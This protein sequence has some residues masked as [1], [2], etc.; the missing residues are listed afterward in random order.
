MRGVTIVQSIQPDSAVAPR[1]WL[2]SKEFD[3]AF[4]GGPALVGL[5]SAFAVVSNPDLWG[6]ILLADLW[7]LGY[8]HVISTYTR[9]A[10]DAQSRRDHLALLTWVPLLVV[11]GVVTLGYGVGLWTLTTTYLYWQW[12]HYTRQSW[13]VLRVYGRKSGLADP[14]PEWLT[15][16]VFYGIPLWGILWRTLQAPEEFLRVELRVPPIPAF[17][18]HTVGILAIV[19]LVGVMMIRFRA[20]RAGN[21]SF[22]Q[23]LY[24]ASHFVMFTVGYVLIENID[25]GWLA[26]NIWHN[27]QYIAFVWYFNNQRFK[28]GESATAPLLSRI[29]QRDRLIT[30]VGGSI[31]LSAVVYVTLGLTIAAVVAP[32]VVYQAVNFHHYVVDSVIWKVR[33]KPMQETLGLTN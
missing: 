8:H 30:Y 5:V 29:S 7:L 21:A 28:E 19:G 12:F 9:L 13:G 18:V 25:H 2:R 24:L 22:G 1:G 3:L 6:I 31:V 32:I 20:Y 15:K 11:A 17:V 10:M 26:I 4:I 23:T 16:A 14:E 33:K 27:A